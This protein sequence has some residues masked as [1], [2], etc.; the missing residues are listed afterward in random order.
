M[1]GAEEAIDRGGGEPRS[2]QSI[3]LG[4]L[5]VMTAVVGLLA[6]RSLRIAR[7]VAAGL[8]ELR[9]EGR[10]HFVRAGT[11][12]L[13]GPLVRKFNAAS[14]EVQSRI[15]RLERER[16]QL[17]VV[18]EAMAEGV[19]AV[20][21][22]QRLLYANAGANR[23]FGL[24]RA[25]VGRMVPELIRS[26]RVQE[27]VEATLGLTAPRSYRAEVLVAGRDGAT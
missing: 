2:M 24:D 18:L 1:W 12:G 9:R 15:D 25:S 21:P 20:D 7:D 19:I 27:A 8:E 16:L 5:A 23:L 10:A 3:L 13:L 17:L 26:P 14:A 11:T 22:R 6:W 4:L